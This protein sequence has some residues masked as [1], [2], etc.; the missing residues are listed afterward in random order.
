[1]AV[2]VDTEGVVVRQGARPGIPTRQGQYV[3]PSPAP[4]PR[5]AAPAPRAAAASFPEEQSL[6]NLAMQDIAAQRAA[7]EQDLARQ[8]GFSTQQ[9]G[10]QQA[11]VA[12]HQNW[13]QQNIDQFLAQQA[14]EKGWR[15][16][17]LGTA[18]AQIASSQGWQDEDLALWLQHQGTELGWTKED[19]DRQVAL[20]KEN[21]P[22]ALGRLASTFAARGSYH[23][24]ARQEAESDL[25]QQ[26]DLQ[27]DELNRDLARTLERAE[28][29]KG[30]KLTE[31]E[32]SKIQSDWEKTQLQQGVERA[33]VQ[34][35]WESTGALGPVRGWE[36]EIRDL[37]V[38][39]EMNQTQETFRRETMSLE[40]QR[41]L[42]SLSRQQQGQQLQW[43]LGR[44]RGAGGGGGGA[45]EVSR[46][47]MGAWRNARFNQ[48]R[49]AGYSAADAQA[50]AIVEAKIR[51][52]G[53]EETYYWSGDMGFL[54]TEVPKVWG[55]Y[56]I[57]AQR[58]FDLTPAKVN[59]LRSKP[60]YAGV[61]KDAQR[62]VRE[63][64]G[65][66]DKAF[67]AWY[68]KT[69]PSSV[70]G[71]VNNAQLASVVLRDLRYGT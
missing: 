30:A 53:L 70:A 20:L 48:L 3:K 50:Q 33:G 37:T 13:M 12:E 8:L 58:A 44:R 1:M 45:A 57:S 59:L 9:Q 24:G 19:V 56:D 31:R 46:N 68:V 7:T 63:T 40:A 16:Q 18:L 6:Q 61:M 10:Q 2:M 41:Q 23:S 52:P 35:G 27:I 4:A 69:Y 51:Y 11:S 38:Q 14:Q 28:W 49:S 60:A 32:R 65:G 62:W 34:A 25:A 42:A 22:E 36:R 64:G 26:F 21:K 67:L 54:E 43:S 29:E 55:R 5:R 15:E 71:L 47:E 39:N 66:T 17:D